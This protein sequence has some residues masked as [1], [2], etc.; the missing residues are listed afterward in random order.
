MKKTIVSLCSLVLAGAFLFGATGCSDKTE[1]RGLVDRG[2][3]EVS[4][5]D[6]SIVAAVKMDGNGA[7]SYTVEKIKRE[8][9]EV[10]GD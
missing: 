8:C 4:S 3:W 1:E 10:A 7:L 6:G 9:R 5:P 2:N